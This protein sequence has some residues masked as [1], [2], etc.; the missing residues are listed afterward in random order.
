MVNHEWHDT[1]SWSSNWHNT[2]QKKFY[3]TN[4]TN[5]FLHDGILD[6]QNSSRRKMELNWIEKL[7]Q[8]ISRWQHRSNEILDNIIM[9]HWNESTFGWKSWVISQK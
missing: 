5:E 7:H 6:Q 9:S 3:T 8:W 4:W 2:G 1:E